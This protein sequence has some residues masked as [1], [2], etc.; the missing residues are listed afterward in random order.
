MFFFSDIMEKGFGIKNP[1]YREQA[2]AI[3]T[4]LKDL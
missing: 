3:G 2:Y 1:E 4:N